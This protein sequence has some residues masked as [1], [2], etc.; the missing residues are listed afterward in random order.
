MFQEQG[1]CFFIDLSC[2]IPTI[3]FYYFS[4]SLLSV[5]RLVLWGWGLQT[6]MVYIPISALHCQ[7]CLIIIIIIIIIIIMHYQHEDLAL[8]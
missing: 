5:Y 2:A 4:V 3:V 8:S 7:P 1:Q 6:E